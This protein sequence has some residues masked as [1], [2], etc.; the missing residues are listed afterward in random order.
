[1]NKKRKNNLDALRVM[2]AFMVVLLH[3]SAYYVGDNINNYNYNFTIGNFFDSISRISVPLFVML[4][5]S[6]LI[7]NNK[8]RCYEYFIK[9]TLKKIILPTLIWSFLY[10][11]YSI[12]LQIPNAFSGREIDYITPFINWV[13]G[14]PYY[15]MWYM[16]MIIGLYLITP[17]LIDIK[18]E[19][20]KKKFFGLGIAFLFIGVFINLFSDLFWP[21]KFIMYIGYFI[22]GYSLKEHYFD[23]KVNYKKY[24][25]ISILFSIFIF[26]LTEMIVKNNLISDKL[27]FY[28]YLSP[29]VIISSVFMFIAFL[30][31][32]HIKFPK[33]ILNISKHT[34]NI[35][36]IHAGVLNIFF[37][38]T[39]KLI[40]YKPNPIW[41][42]PLLT[43]VIFEISYGISIVIEKFIK[44]E[45]KSLFFYKKSK[46]I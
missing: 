43:L 15:H 27:Y 7:S 10:V 25:F 23:K 39:D 2:A 38:L 34:F 22:L 28:D 36:L 18:S 11:I 9:K 14:I 16:Y 24:L 1:M 35:Y 3:V 37:R 46:N 19:L 41:Y 31:M 12:L 4:S 8:N 5:G 21:L 40:G 26:L 17:F 32:N 6:F 42:I 45:N 44:K 33:F 29:F 13:Y 30:N 20:K